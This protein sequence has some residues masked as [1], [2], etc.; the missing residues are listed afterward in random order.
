MPVKIL[1][2][3]LIPLCSGLI[4]MVL[5][6]DSED[7]SIAA[8]TGLTT[9][10]TCTPGWNVVVVPTIT[11]RD[12]TFA[13]VAGSAAT[14]VW[15]VGGYTDPS[16]PSMPTL[17]LVEHWNG[18][19]WHIAAAPNAGTQANYLAAII[20][21][22]STNAWAVG[23]YLGITT[24]LTLVEHWDG[25]AWSVVPSP[26]QGTS[27][28]GLQAIAAVAPDDIWAGGVW[29]SNNIG[30][31]LIEHWDGSSWT[32]VP[33]ADD[34][35]T[36]NQILGLAALAPDNIWAVGTK[37]DPNLVGVTYAVIQHWDG[38]TWTL[39]PNAGGSHLAAVGGVA[40]NDV[41][42][43]GYYYPAG[44]A[45]QQALIEHWDGTAWSRLPSPATG[46]L[47]SLSVRAANDIWAAGSVYHSDTGTQTLVAHWNGTTWQVVPSPNGDGPRLSRLFG[48]VALTSQEVWAVGIHDLYTA[49]HY[50]PL[51]LHYAPGNP[52]GT[53]T[54][55]PRDTATATPTA[56]R[57]AIP[58]NTATATV[59]ATG[60]PP[61]TP[62]A[63][64]ATATGTG[65]P[66]LTATATGT[67]TAGATGVSPT[68][69]P[70]ATPTA[71]R[72]VPVTNT[73]TVGATACP[74]RFSDVTDP[75]AYYYPGVYALACRGAISGYNDGTFR[76]FNPTTRG[77]MTKIVT[78]AFTLPLVPPPVLG[79]H[80]FTDVTPAN[81]FYQLIETAAAQGIVSGYTCGGVNTQTGAAE[82]CDS[83]NRPYF[84]PNNAV[85]RGQLTK[86]VVSGAG[87]ALRTP[88]TPTFRDVAPSNVFYP[89]IETAVCH[90]VISGYQDGTFRPNTSAFRG[91]IAKIVYLA[92]TTA[93]GTCAGQ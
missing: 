72:S 15:A 54:A 76:P 25:T 29:Y 50:R 12:H 20:V 78:L 13:A 23:R 47:D 81:V 87:F 80:T 33:S 73:A 84:R 71:T 52:C 57:T 28:N 90:A 43:V 19:D 11:D 38:T 53:R 77:Q 67:P 51:A 34:G 36:G 86:I 21:P 91:Q 60:G 69:I 79:N 44:S 92:V 42:A 45:D 17:N 75:A 31:T 89:F 39:V 58:R 88:P 64:V 5:L 30:H 3:L 22:T 16:Q 35:P 9:T 85:T 32:I 63:G 62:S 10:A 55:I 70:T 27:Y 14:D 48:I 46:R 24:S 59:T 56:T 61:T 40:A 74:I 7:A 26:N 1:Q 68:A 83:R 41:W 8:G 82:P 37:D 49:N 6:I 4:L 2:T 93:P 66:P 65:V 18:A